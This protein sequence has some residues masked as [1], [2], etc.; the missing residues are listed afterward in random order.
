MSELKAPLPDRPTLPMIG[1]TTDKPGSRTGTAL[2]CAVR[3]WR[4]REAQVGARFLSGGGRTRVS[5]P[6]QLLFQLRHRD[7]Q[8]KL[9]PGV[10]IIH[11]ADQQRLAR[12]RHRTGF[13][14]QLAHDGMKLLGGLRIG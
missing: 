1:V 9:P 11:D 12:R 14:F 8:L 4:R 2:L 6:T 3:V 5:A 10:G 7:L 13:N